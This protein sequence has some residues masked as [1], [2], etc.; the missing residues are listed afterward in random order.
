MARKDKEA[1]K[2]YNAK[3]WAEHKK[4]ISEKRKEAYQRDKDKIKVRNKKWVEKNREKW[5][6]Y[7]REYRKAKKEA[8]EKESS[9]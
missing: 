2:E 4:E 9:A 7:L 5:N 8:N 3:Y 1:T 6:A